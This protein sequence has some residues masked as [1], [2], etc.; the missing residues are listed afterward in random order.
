MPSRLDASILMRVPRPGSASLATP[1]PA[2]AA[3]A[4]L[5]AQKM[6]DA[7]AISSDQ[8]TEARQFA[9]TRGMDV[10]GALIELH[11]ATHTSVAQGI[12]AATQTTYISLNQ[13]KIDESIL[14][15]LPES[16]ARENHVL[17]IADGVGALSV[18][19]S[20]PQDLETIEKLRFILN[21]N[22]IA[23]CGA[24]DEIAQS[25]N[26]HYGQMEGESADSMLQEF[27]DT[28]IDF[29]QSDDDVDSSDF[30]PDVVDEI[31]AFLNQFQVGQLSL[32]AR[33]AHRVDRAEKSQ[34]GPCIRLT[35]ELLQSDENNAPIIRLVVLLV[36]EAIQMRATHIIARMEAAAIQFEFVIDGQLVQ[37]DQ[38]PV[39]LWWSILIHV[40]RLAKLDL[41]RCDGVQSCTIKMTVGEAEHEMVVHAALRSFMIEL[42]AAKQL[43]AVPEAIE[44]WHA[45]YEATAQA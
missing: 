38:V 23:F 27:T 2:L 33:S 21:R 45:A 36:A 37:R 28:Q 11:Y 15:Q 19:M 17:P 44:K 32:T 41:V 40:L 26:E 3:T 10:C 20:N 42:S 18:V 31:N 30:D 22:I 25:I 1:H 13:L 24:H 43:P 12:A 7:G 5:A 6:L 29:S 34:P 4:E 39:R 35:P 14:L 16:V 8:L 9:T